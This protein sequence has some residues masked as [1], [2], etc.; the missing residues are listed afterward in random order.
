M[1]LQPVKGR[2][3]ESDGWGGIDVGERGNRIERELWHVCQVTS[4]QRKNARCYLAGALARGSGSKHP[5][6]SGFKY[7]LILTAAWLD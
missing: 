6:L 1:F 7:K 2:T 4:R 5:G 3:P